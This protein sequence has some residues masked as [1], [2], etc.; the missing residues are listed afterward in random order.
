[1]DYQWGHTETFQRTG[2]ATMKLFAVDFET[3]EYLDGQAVTVIN[4]KHSVSDCAKN[5]I[6]Y[7]TEKIVAIREVPVVRQPTYP[8]PDKL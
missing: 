1:M 6:T 2:T 8:L 7:G 4:R 3:T 5:A